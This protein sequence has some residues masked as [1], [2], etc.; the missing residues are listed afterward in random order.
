MQTYLWFNYFADDPRLRSIPFATRRP[1]F[2]EVKRVHAE[3]STVEILGEFTIYKPYSLG[4][5]IKSSPLSGP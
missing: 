5:F 1:T 4:D 3:L 2:N